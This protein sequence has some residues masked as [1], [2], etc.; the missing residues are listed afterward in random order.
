MSAF[1]RFVSG[2]SAI[3]GAAYSAF[4][5]VLAGIRSLRHGHSAQAT[6][7]RLMKVNRRR[8]RDHVFRRSKRLSPW[9]P[10]TLK[11]LSAIAY[12]TPSRTPF[13]SDGGQH[14]TLMADG[15]PS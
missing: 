1:R 15:V 8:L 13:R 11:V 4:F 9:P 2:C 12:S 6:K 10:I 14:S 3:Q 5:G 7:A